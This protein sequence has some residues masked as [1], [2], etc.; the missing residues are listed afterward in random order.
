MVLMHNLSCL[1]C[2]L[3]DFHKSTDTLVQKCLLYFLISTLVSLSL[4]LPMKSH[5]LSGLRCQTVITIAVR[6]RTLLVHYFK[7][8]IQCAAFIQCVAVVKIVT[9][10]FAQQAICLDIL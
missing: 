4:S 8:V 5:L 7:Q 10:L 1:Y 2:M 3:G 9:L 6:I